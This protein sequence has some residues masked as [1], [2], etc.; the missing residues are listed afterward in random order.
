VVPAIATILLTDKLWKQLVLGWSMGTIVS[1]IGLL[2]SYYADLPSGP[3][4]VATYGLALLILSLILYLVRSENKPIAIRNLIMGIIVVAI[5]SVGFYGLAKFFNGEEEHGHDEPVATS[6]LPEIEH[7]G[8]EHNSNEPSKEVEPK[9]SDELLLLLEQTSDDFEKIDI[10][11]KLIKVDEKEGLYRTIQFLE[12]T[13]VPFL[14]EEAL[15][16]LKEHSKT[17]FGYDSIKSP[18]ENSEAIQKFY[19]WWT[20]KYS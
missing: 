19:E 16:I 5:T 7:S 20:Q 8:N 10:L 2:T 1:I 11:Q 3:T 4:V 13:K 14:R 18:E 6:I 9:N 15:S 17:N 12:N